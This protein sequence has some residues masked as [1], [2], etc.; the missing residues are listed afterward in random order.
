M[1]LKQFK[2]VTPG[3]RQLILVD[4]SG[5]W[6]G[7]PEKSLTEGM[8]KTGGRNNNGHITTRHIGG[9]AKRLYRKIDFKRRKD[10]VFAVVERIEYDPNRSAFIALI[11]YQSDSTLAYILA[12]Q[13][14]AVGDKVVSGDRVDIK[15]GNALPLKSIPVGTIVHNVEMK[16]G[17]GG[18]LAR[19]AGTYAQ[20][21]GR[22]LG[23][24]Q[25]RLSS[26]ELRVVPGD[27][28]ASIGAVSNPDQKN[29]S[30]G[31]AGRNRWFGIRP[32]VRGIAMNPV[33]H[34]HG[35]RTNGGRHPV[36]PW[37]IATKGRKTRH[38]K[39]SDKHIISRRKK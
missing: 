15:P 39:P 6:K 32:T 1:A 10:D 8:T 27:C 3:Q 37:G 16:A 12:P 35:G 34:P 26:G 38:K 21:V 14:L 2:P 33:D 9:G 30:I 17:K 23:L 19:S 20:I 25:L 36:T 13:R 11:R 31:K 18:Q 29:I 5:L 24:I 28:R 22:D 4:R 7:R